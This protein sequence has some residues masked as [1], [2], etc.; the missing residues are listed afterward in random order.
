MQACSCAGSNGTLDCIRGIQDHAM[1]QISVQYTP[2]PQVDH[3]V[4]DAHR[5]LTTK[6]A[7]QT[8]LAPPQIFVRYPL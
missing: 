7:L 5:D 8:F 2:L 1:R 4:R 3:V 6:L